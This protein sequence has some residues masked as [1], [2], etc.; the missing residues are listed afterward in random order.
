LDKED[1]NMA[2]EE[3]EIERLKAKLTKLKEIRDSLRTVVTN[4]E[5]SA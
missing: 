1:E 4:N 5:T 2:K 3:L